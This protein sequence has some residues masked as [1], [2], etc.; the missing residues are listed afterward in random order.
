MTDNLT[1]RPSVP[2]SLA[3]RASSLRALAPDL[4]RGFMLLLIAIVHA[5]VFRS[6]WSGSG[7]S[8]S[9]PVD[10]AV[11]GLTTLLADDRG[12]ALFAV[13]F[14]YGVAQLYHRGTADG[15]EWPVLRVL[16]RRRG[17]WLVVIGLAHTVLLFFGDMLA[18][19][20]LIVLAFAGALRWAG[21]R[22]L[23]HAF[24]W[25]AGGTLVYAFGLPMIYQLLIGWNSVAPG[26]A[27]VLSDLQYRLGWPLMMPLAFANAVFPFLIGVWAAR[28]R[29]LDEP[30][31]NR[32]LLRAVAGYG[33]TISVLAGLPYAL[34][35]VGM[36]QASPMTYTG[37]YWVNLM[38]SYAG[39]FGYAA[40]FAL[41]AIRIGQRR[42]P[43]VGALVATGQRS[44]TCYLL[45]SVAWMVLSAPYL[46]GL[47][48]SMSNIAAAGMGVGV[49]LVTVLMADA[50]ARRGIRGPAE[51]FYRRMT[52]GRTRA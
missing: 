29:V 35:S 20:G 8:A 24:A 2:G 32:K 37:V 34:L 5:S 41:I 27:T 48:N 40:V 10:L 15:Q 9:D 11:S 42:G 17:L 23:A 31:R 14:G 49:W 33:V 28:R 16:L 21:R 26:E 18:V 22:L 43:V 36:W 19:Y 52:Y 25:L 44:M 50:M 1:V 38:S 39:G 12:F 46:L 7:F 4:S 45:Q 30:E 6:A 3:P 13:L 47:Q 51:T